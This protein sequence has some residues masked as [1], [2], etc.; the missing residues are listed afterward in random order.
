MAALIGTAAWAAIACGLGW[1]QS[2]A[3]SAPAVTNVP[4]AEY[5]RV[6]SD[7]S[8]TFRIQA[9]EARKIQVRLGKDYDMVRAE[10]GSWSVRIP[11]QVPGF[12]YYYLVVDGVQVSDPASRS[13]FGVSRDSSGIEIP[14]KGVDYYQVKDVPH[15]EIRQFR[16]Y[17][18]VTGS[19]RRAYVYTP[20]DYDANLKARYPVLLLLHGGGEDETGWV[21]QG[22]T[23]IILD[24]LIAEKKA[25]PMIVVMDN[26]GARK[27]GEPPQQGPP[28]SPS[29]ALLSTTF[30][31][32]LSTTFSE[33]VIKDM[34]PALD[35]RYRTLADREHRAIAGLSMGAAYAMQV[36][37]G[38][39][40]TFSHFGSFSG[41]VMRDLDAKTSYGGVLSDGARFNQK[42]RLM[43]IS[44]GTAEQS[45]LDAARHARRELDKVGVK[46]VAYDSPGT[47]HE[48][49]TWRRALH[50]FAQLLFR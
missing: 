8:V 33:V 30:R 14:E 22:K 36:G 16:Y 26:T 34:L 18:G 39:L 17:S 48:W 37:L 45:R 29:G 19:W 11:P 23:D 6:H 9:P 1:C 24:N 20:P 10:D 40:D 15:G 3:D 12:H 47:D 2:P 21:V 42:C 25:A 32:T 49:L 4:G 27:P 50:Q 35:K 13:F 5:P 28:V 31:V 38:N 41:T 43:F 7:H 44:A 46:Y